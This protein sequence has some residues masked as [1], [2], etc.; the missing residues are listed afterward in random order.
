MTGEINNGQRLPVSFGPY[1]GK[2][3]VVERSGI[4]QVSFWGT[5]RALRSC[6]AGEVD[7]VSHHVVAVE[8]SAAVKGMVVLTVEPVG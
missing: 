2:A 8:D 6:E 4:K 7:G 3:G 5:R 1:E